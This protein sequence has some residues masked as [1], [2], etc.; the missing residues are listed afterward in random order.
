MNNPTPRNNKSR[1]KT[2]ID[3]ELGQM[4]DGAYQ[5]DYKQTDESTQTSL[6]APKGADNKLQL[7]SLF[8]NNSRSSSIEKVKRESAMMKFMYG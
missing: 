8:P 4:V 5:T 7:S 6:I 1:L 3:D 2:D